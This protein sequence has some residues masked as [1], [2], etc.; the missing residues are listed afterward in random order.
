MGI[1]NKNNFINTTKFIKSKI[2]LKISSNIFIK[3]IY[4]KI[5]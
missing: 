5:E 4:S 1:I 2:D 3:N